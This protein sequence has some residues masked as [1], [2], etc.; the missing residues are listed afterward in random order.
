MIFQQRAEGSGRRFVTNKMDSV[1]NQFHSHYRN[2]QW[3]KEK[4]IQ[5]LL[6]WGGLEVGKATCLIEI[7]TLLWYNKLCNWKN[8]DF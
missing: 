3:K 2:K 5:Q 7:V 6:G 1:K 8:G 4:K